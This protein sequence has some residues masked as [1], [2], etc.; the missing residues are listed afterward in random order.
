MKIIN[1]I[2][3]ESNEKPLFS[4]NLTPQGFKQ[5]E[6]L[7]N[8]LTNLK[9]DIVFCSPFIRTVDT[10]F[11][12]INE[13]NILLNLENSLMEY[14]D[15]DIHTKES[16][17]YDFNTYKQNIQPIINKNYTSF[18]PLE[19]VKIHE[20]EEQ[21]HKRTSNFLNFLKHNYNNKNIL[22]V[23]HMSTC[24]SLKKY[25]IPKTGTEDRFDMGSYEIFE[26]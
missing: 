1:L 9:I 7:V 22:L 25:F 3:C 12:Y 8:K 18:L 10:I 4:T 11:P 23:S 14:L 13:N 21:L 5:A 19:N 15:L 2:H 26:L 16:I 6:S 24:N 17:Q 20:I